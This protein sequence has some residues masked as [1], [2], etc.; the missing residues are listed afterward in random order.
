MGRKKSAATLYK[1]SLT[2]DDYVLNG[3]VPF[4]KSESERLITVF[5]KYM[6][7][8]NIDKSDWEYLRGCAEKLANI[9]ECDES[10]M[11][12]F[13]KKKLLDIKYKEKHSSYYEVVAES[14]A[15]FFLNKIHAVD[16]SESS[17]VNQNAYFLFAAAKH[18]YMFV[19]CPEKI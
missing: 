6:V 13:N 10:F 8:K 16:N 12:P 2:Y 3:V 17:D 1:E 18:L 11:N 7:N 9:S 15:K 5:D 19:A 14:F 4:M